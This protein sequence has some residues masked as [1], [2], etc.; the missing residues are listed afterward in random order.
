MKTERTNQARLI[1]DQK[2]QLRRRALLMLPGAVIMETHGGFGRI[3]GQAYQAAGPGVVFEADPTAAGALAEQRPT[4]AVYETKAA[5]RAI[6]EGAGAHLAVNF[7][8]IDAG[9]DP[10]PYVEAFFGSQRPRPDRLAIVAGDLNRKKL[11]LNGASIGS[12]REEVRKYGATGIYP[13]YLEVCREKL[14]ERAARVGYELKKW[15]GYY[16]GTAGS[17][18][19]YAAIFERKTNPDGL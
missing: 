17:H 11:R 9:G 15:S 13:K 4:W 5:D 2:V 3:F 18:T 7:V 1:F 8:D 14:T 6:F 12:L 19:H 16:C 10:W